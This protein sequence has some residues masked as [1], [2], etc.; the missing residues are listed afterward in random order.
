MPAWNWLKFIETNMVKWLVK[1]GESYTENDVMEA[2]HVLENQ[3]LDR[4][5][6]SKEYKR[7]LEMK[8]DIWMLYSEYL[9]TGNQIHLKS[10][11]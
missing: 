2:W 3:C 1:E 11:L 6:H 7:I 10:I 5:G 9:E 8:H 4:F